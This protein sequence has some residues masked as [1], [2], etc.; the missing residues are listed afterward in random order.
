MLRQ[1]P[2]Q[3]K[4]REDLKRLLKVASGGIVFTTVQKF[5]PTDGNVYEE[6][7]NRI[8]QDQVFESDFD[9]EVKKILGSGKGKVGEEYEN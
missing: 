6:L 5:Q 8:T 4:D 9:R 3:A 1:E 7:S 2:V